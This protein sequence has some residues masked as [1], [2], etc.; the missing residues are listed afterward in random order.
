MGVSRSS[1]GNRKAALSLTAVRARGAATRL[2]LLSLWDSCSIIWLPISPED[3]GDFPHVKPA[4]EVLFESEA[5]PSGVDA[6]RRC[7][8]VP[9]GAWEVR[10][11]SVRVASS[12]LSSF[13][14]FQLPQRSRIL[15]HNRLLRADT[16][17]GT[18]R[19]SCRHGTA[20]IYRIRIPVAFPLGAKVDTQV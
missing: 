11:A 9:V 10:R 14:S 4:A 7:A 12:W 6:G 8:G 20:G 2:R 17:R 16:I 5:G 15:P 19:R 3:Y 18:P 13:C 1:R